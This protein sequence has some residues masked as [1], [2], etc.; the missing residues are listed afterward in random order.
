MAEKFLQPPQPLNLI[1][2]QEELKRSEFEPACY[3]V[4]GFLRVA[5]LSVPEI[6]SLGPGP[7]KIA[8]G[9]SLPL[10]AKGS[11]FGQIPSVGKFR[12]WRG[13]LLCPLRLH[14]VQSDC[15]LE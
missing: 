3:L 1:R 9:V 4:H 12:R 11:P 13:G 6:A 7:A 10:A 8:L 2:R 5:L 15:G 14:D